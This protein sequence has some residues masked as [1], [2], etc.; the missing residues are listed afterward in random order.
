MTEMTI[1][2]V[3]GGVL[4]FA[5]LVVLFLIVIKP[6]RNVAES[7]MSIGEAEKEEL[8]ELKRICEEKP[9][10]DC[11][12]DVAVMSFE[13]K[14]SS[15]IV[16]SW[17]KRQIE[18]TSDPVLLQKVFDF[19]KNT[20]YPVSKDYEGAVEI[21]GLLFAK[22]HSPEAQFARDTSKVLSIYQQTTKFDENTMRQFLG[23]KKVELK[24]ALNSVSTLY[25]NNKLADTPLLGSCNTL[26]SVLEKDDYLSQHPEDDL[27][28]YRACSQLSRQS[29]A[30]ACFPILDSQQGSRCVACTGYKPS[31]ARADDPCSGY[32][33]RL[34]CESDSCSINAVCRWEQVFGALGRCV[35]K[36]TF[37][38]QG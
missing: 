34:A 3:L 20:F 31:S 27:N 30:T 17:L 2:K 38:V 32:N 11:A 6:L 35:S 37:L 1:G 25:R 8:T 23:T 24:D 19:A 14:E 26:F 33:N 15:L 18:A 7:F 29:A 22:L 36:Q 5:L 13:E 4:V 16:Q 10:E 21:Y 28:P 12:F 9:T